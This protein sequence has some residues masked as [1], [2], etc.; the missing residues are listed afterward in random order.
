[1][2]KKGHLGIS[3]TSSNQIFFCTKSL[4]NEAVSNYFCRNHL[5]GSILEK[6]SLEKKSKVVHFFSAATLCV[7]AGV[8]NGE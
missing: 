4:R 8:S 7:C 1:V 2:S 3:H 5:N 6:K